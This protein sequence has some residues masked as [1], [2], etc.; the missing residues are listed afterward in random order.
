MSVTYQSRKA[1]IQ[2]R[3]L[4]SAAVALGL[5]TS[6]ANSAPVVINFDDVVAPSSFPTQTVQ[7]TNQYA[8]FGV[9]FTTPPTE[10]ANEVLNNSSFT[11]PGGATNPNLLASADFLAIEGFFTGP[12]FSVGA[13][14]G[15]S[16]GS[17]RLSIFDAAGN[18][19]AS[20]VGDDVF[21]SLTSASPIARFTVTA[22]T[23]ST[24]AIDNLTFE[25]G[26]AQV[27][28]PSSVTLVG[29]SLLALLSLKRRR[30]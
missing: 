4:M 25:V 13:L 16:G 7:L 15:I 12:V 27:P 29:L 28:E 6:S 2:T 5:W 24:P 14:I 18:L 3:A 30:A 22:A 19:L 9:L 20:V 21:V 8:S 11:V 26:A 23:E 1:M 17:D 10:N